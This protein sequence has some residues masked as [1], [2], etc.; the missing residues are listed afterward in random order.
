MLFLGLSSSTASIKLAMV[1]P[2]LQFHIMMLS[3]TAT[4]GLL[5]LFHVI[6]V[7]GALIA[8]LIM[9]LRQFVSVLCNAVWFGSHMNIS[10]LGWAAI[11]L[12]AAGVWIKM[13]RRYDDLGI[14]GVSPPRYSGLPSRKSPFWIRQYLIPLLVCPLTFV[15]LTPAMTFTALGHPST[16]V[17]MSGGS[18]TIEIPSTEVMM[19]GESTTV[20]T[21][22]TEATMSG[23]S[24]ATEKPSTEVMG[25]GSLTIQT[26]SNN[27]PLP[28]KGGNLLSSHV[29]EAQ[30]TPAPEANTHP[31]EA[32][33]IWDDMLVKA[34]NSECPRGPLN[35]VKNNNT[36][37]TALATYPRS[38]SSYTR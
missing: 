31:S 7:H 6:A 12:V 26:S 25:G 13:D 29:T 14:T 28:I 11:G 38:G 19:R 8:G 1:S 27:P 16:E 10:P 9:T 5:L 32:G 4:C 35:S 30:P 2:V 34:V 3:L 18:I 33:H 17:I 23:E 21:P 22:S 36:I 37:R 24:I 15:F 20:Q